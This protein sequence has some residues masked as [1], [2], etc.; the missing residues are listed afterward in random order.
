[1]NLP[2]DVAIPLTDEPHENPP[3]WAADSRHIV[4]EKRSGIYLLDVENPDRE[5]LITTGFHADI[6]MEAEVNT[7]IERR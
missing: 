6:F 2:G 5:R 7:G 1:M 3:R 4:Y